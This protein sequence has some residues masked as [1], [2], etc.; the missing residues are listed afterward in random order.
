M[1]AHRLATIE[2]C[3]RIHLL[4]RGQV[5]ASGSYQEL[6]R[7]QPTFRAFAHGGRTDD[8]EEWVAPTPS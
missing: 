1:V 4:E 7:T 3:D 6:P 2:A 5:I 8:D